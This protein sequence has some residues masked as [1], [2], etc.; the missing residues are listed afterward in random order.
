MTSQAKGQSLFTAACD[1]CSKFLRHD[2]Q[3]PGIFVTSDGRIQVR[4]YCTACDSQS[5][6][7]PQKDLVVHELPVKRSNFEG[8]SL[9]RARQYVKE[10]YRAGVIS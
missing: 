5:E 4:L 1:L 10:L 9:K 7:V 6:S 2:A 3:E 8:G